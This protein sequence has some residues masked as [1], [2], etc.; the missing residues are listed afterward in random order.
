MKLPTEFFGTMGRLVGELKL[1]TVVVQ[2]GGYNLATAGE[3][4]AEFLN[5]DE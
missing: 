3:C 1:P 5:R 2:E 4:V